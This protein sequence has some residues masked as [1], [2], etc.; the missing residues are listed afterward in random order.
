MEKNEIFELI[1]ILAKTSGLEKDK[2][3]IEI[4]RNNKKHKLWNT[5]YLLGQVLRQYDIPMERC[6]VSNEAKNLW[7]KLGIKDDINSFFWKEKLNCNCEKVLVKCYVGSNNKYE[8]KEISTNTYLEYRSVFHN[9]HII[10]IDTIKEKLEKL[11]IED[12]LDDDKIEEILNMICICRITK[13]EDRN[14]IKK[15]NRPDNLLTCYKE[16]YKNARNAPIIIEEL[17]KLITD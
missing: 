4:I 17:E 1:K 12:N 14:I 6:F 8:N 10:P 15:Y 3:Y 2:R 16:I 7:K 11:A 9:E 13:E 5:H